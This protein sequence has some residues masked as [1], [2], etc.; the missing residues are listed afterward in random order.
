MVPL[1]VTTLEISALPILALITER[2]LIRL[3]QPIIMAAIVAGNW[4]QRM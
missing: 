3:E 4:K 2:T 1:A